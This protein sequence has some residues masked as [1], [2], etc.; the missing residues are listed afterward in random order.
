[1]LK[2]DPANDGIGEFWVYSSSIQ[3][4]GSVQS[5]ASVNRCAPEVLPSQINLQPLSCFRA[6]RKRSNQEGFSLN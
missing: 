1:M 4:N 2:F 3:T 6:C 5:N